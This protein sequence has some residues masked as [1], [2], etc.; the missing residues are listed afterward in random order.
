MPRQTITTLL[1]LLTCSALAC[2]STPRA[3][4]AP[5]TEP[6]VEPAAEGT[7]EEPADGSTDEPSDET[8]IMGDGAPSFAG[9][10]DADGEYLNN[11]DV[12]VDPDTEAT[13]SVSDCFVMST[14]G[15]GEVEF[16]FELNFDMEHSCGMS[17][18]AF[19]VDGKLVYEGREETDDAECVLEIVV[20][21]DSIELRE[22]TRGC[23]PFWCGA[24]GAIDGAAFARSTRRD[25]TGTCSP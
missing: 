2:S 11:H 22:P 3:E 18:S 21:D 15:S 13:A 5:P 6:V 8:P 7:E 23:S 24:R 1:C 9:P 12:Y 4:E 14:L 17:G 10:L 19:P 20:G 16:A 25:A